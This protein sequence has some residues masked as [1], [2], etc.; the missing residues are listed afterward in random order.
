MITHESQASLEAVRRRRTAC[1]VCWPA[2]ISCEVRTTVHASLLDE[3]A[4]LRLT[5]ELSALGIEHHKI[6]EFRS[7]GCVTPTLTL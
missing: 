1:G 6:Q 2:G 7:T 4:L 3:D 5:A